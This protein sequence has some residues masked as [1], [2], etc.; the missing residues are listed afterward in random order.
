MVAGVAPTIPARC[1]YAA[2]IHSGKPGIAVCVAVGSMTRTSRRPFSVSR[3][4][5]WWEPPS[6]EGVPAE[7][8]DATADVAIVMAKYATGL[9]FHRLARM[10]QSFGVP[11]PESVQW[12]RCEAVADALLP[13]Y[14][15]LRTRA[16]QADVLV[17]DDT[18]VQILSC[19]QENQ[20]RT[21]DERQGLHTTGTFRKNGVPA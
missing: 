21:A 7:K 6:T 9:P 8:Y 20:Q 13:V 4:S 16:A 14:L 3:A 5:R 12:E 11:L 17:S 19:E 18:R 1:V 15:Q 10:Q 2:P